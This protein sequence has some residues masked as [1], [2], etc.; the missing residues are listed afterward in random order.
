MSKEPS[1]WVNIIFAVSPYLM[2]AATFGLTLV[3]N[4]LDV[5]HYL[6]GVNLATAANTLFPNPT[7]VFEREHLKHP[8]T[9]LVVNLVDAQAL[10]FLSF[11]G[12][13][14]YLVLSEHVH[15]TVALSAAINAQG[16]AAM[17]AFLL[18][19][20][21]CESIYKISVGVRNLII[22][23]FSIGVVL[24]PP[25]YACM[26]GYAGFL[27][28][29]V[30]YCFFRTRLKLTSECGTVPR[31]LWGEYLKAYGLSLPESLFNWADRFLVYHYLSHTNFV[32]YNLV[33][34]I[35]QI[36]YSVFYQIE[37][38]LVFGRHSYLWHEKLFYALGVVVALL[39]PLVVMW[40]GPIPIKADVVVGVSDTLA[41]AV[42][43]I[44]GML[45]AKPNID[46]VYYLSGSHSLWISIISGV[47]YITTLAVVFRL[48]TSTNYLLY[49]YV[50]LVSFA[51]AGCGRWF[52]VRKRR[53]QRPI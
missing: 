50:F 26:F 46:A 51:L 21:G 11:Y 27:A 37:M 28:A 20:Q 34:R 49:F 12:T 43:A 32:V 9:A 29:V 7:L 23:L 52:A 40:L 47:A 5:A 45:V 53:E 39:G 38:K 6:L 19:R 33:R 8:Q 42:A 25:R 44:I 41:V 22:S 48:S 14:I 31:C 16:S 15:L 36:H 1:V 3:G 2:S 30:Q 4:P 13:L 35:S 10:L 24:L 17:F 18:N